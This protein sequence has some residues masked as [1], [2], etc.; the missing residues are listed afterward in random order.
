MEE[1]KKTVKE[2]KKEIKEVNKQ[3][4]KLYN[5]LSIL[6]DVLYFVALPGGL[7]DEI[8]NA[9]HSLKKFI[10]HNNVKEIT[11]LIGSLQAA[12]LDCNLAGKYLKNELNKTNKQIN[13]TDRYIINMK[14][15]LKKLTI[16]ENKK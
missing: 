5:Y 13:T 1:K 10:K 12:K 15:K 3:I 8:I 16:C 4:N 9:E 14:K 7:Q 2:L 11:S 6:D